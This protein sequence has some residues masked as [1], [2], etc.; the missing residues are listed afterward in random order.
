MWQSFKLVMLHLHTGVLQCILENVRIG[1]RRVVLA[2]DDVS[3]REQ[4][5]V[6]IRQK[7]EVRAVLEAQTSLI[8]ENI[9]ILRLV[10]RI[11]AALRRNYQKSAMGRLW[12]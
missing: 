7:H 2:T 4:T 3:G 9:H 10:A 12:V 8:V 11:D 6:A 1:S 5:V